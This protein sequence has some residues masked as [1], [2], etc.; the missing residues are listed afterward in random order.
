[1]KCSCIYAWNIHKNSKFAHWVLR[2]NCFTGMHSNLEVPGQNTSAVEQNF[3]VGPFLSDSLQC[4][5][6]FFTTVMFEMDLYQ[7]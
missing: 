3:K 2:R 4:H 6:T 7:L 1:M 5:L